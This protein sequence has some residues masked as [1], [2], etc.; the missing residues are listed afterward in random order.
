MDDKNFTTLTGKEGHKAGVNA[1]AFSAHS[2]TAYTTS[3]DNTLKKWNLAGD[4]KQ[5][6]EPEVLFTGT[7]CPLLPLPPFSQWPR[8]E[9]KHR[10]KEWVR[11]GRSTPRR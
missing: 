5:G 8:Q 9:P 2:A 11:L 10:R 1:I 3:K 7:P 4:Y 6:F